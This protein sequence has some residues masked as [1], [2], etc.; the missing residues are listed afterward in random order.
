MQ[1]RI[2][3]RPEIAAISADFSNHANKVTAYTFFQDV[4]YTYAKEEEGNWHENHVYLIITFGRKQVYLEYAKDLSTVLI[5]P[6]A[7][8]GIIASYD[9]YY[10]GSPHRLVELDFANTCIDAAAYHALARSDT[11]C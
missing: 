3:Y 5:P 1:R 4:D 11:G 9:N 6:Y 10:G 8:E 7:T 2:C